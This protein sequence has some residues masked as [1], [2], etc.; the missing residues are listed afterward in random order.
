M[1]IVGRGILTIPV[2]VCCLVLGNNAIDAQDTPQEMEYSGYDRLELL[3]R[4]LR[5]VYP[6]LA[7]HQGLSTLR[8][9][10]GS[11]F[12][13]LASVDLEFHPCRMSGVSP[14][15]G[16]LPYCGA[17]ALVGEEPFLNMNIGFANDK[18]RPIWTFS[19]SGTFIE[20][21]RLEAVRNQNKGVIGKEKEL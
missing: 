2:A 7:E 16:P 6:D 14:R 13:R 8:I 9:G 15:P 18:R 10:F 1:S 3:S 4:F 17:P 12:F 11:G 5:T 19:A 21:S 20:D